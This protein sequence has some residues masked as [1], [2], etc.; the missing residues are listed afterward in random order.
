MWHVTR[1]STKLWH[2]HITDTHSPFYY[3]YAQTYKCTAPHHKKVVTDIS[4]LLHANVNVIQL[5]TTLWSRWIT[6]DVQNEYIYSHMRTAIITS[7]C[8][9]DKAGFMWLCLRG[10][11]LNVVRDE[12]KPYFLIQFRLESTAA[13]IFLCQSESEKNDLACPGS[14]WSSHCCGFVLVALI[15]HSHCWDLSLLL[16]FE[17]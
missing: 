3:V 12:R 16:F 11:S 17:K 14:V 5:L 10:N 2:C 15:F 8:L 4:L 13:E 9:E 7:V 6:V 1:I